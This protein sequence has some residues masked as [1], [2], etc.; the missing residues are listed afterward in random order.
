MK[1][2]T[3]ICASLVALAVPLMAQVAEKAAA[4]A[5]LDLNKV[6]LKGVTDKPQPLYKVGEEITF[7][8]WMDFAGQTPDKG[9]YFDWTLTGDDGQKKN[10]RHQVADGKLVVK[11]KLDKP[12]FVR[13]LAIGKDADGKPLTKTTGGG[14]SKRV[15]FDGGAG[16]E[17]EKL[18]GAPEPEDFD[19]FWKQQR[20]R[21][22]A[23]PFEGKAMMTECPSKDAAVKI[24]AVS[25]PCAGPRPVT[26]YMTI[27]AGAKPKSL[28]AH[29]VY[30]GYGL[31][32]QTPPT[33]GSKDKIQFFVNAHGYELGKDK[34]YQD[35]FFGSIREDGCSYG[36]SP[37]R[38]Q[39][40]ET[41]YFF[42]M[43]LRIMRSLQFVMSLPEWDGKNLIASG[44]SQGGLQT[45]WAAGLEPK[46]TEAYPSIP[47]C[48]DMQGKESFGRIHG[49]W[50][51][52]GTPALAYYDPI[53]IAKRIPRTC[54]VNITRAGLGD[55]CCPP[56][57]VAILYNNIKAPKE[58]HWV[59][60]STHGFVP[61]YPECQKFT[62]SQP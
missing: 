36:F 50:R 55:Y 58:I 57:G 7:T 16:A 42:G 54:K 53:N 40:R 59:Q 44:G 45:V 41:T 3:W 33:S 37:K 6:F 15:F 28:P 32:Y 35:A 46:V 23:V 13:L 11:T 51:I 22:A 62:Q 52:V 47:W 30:Y 19:E 1:L 39:N 18:Q 34:A 60:G 49:G 9:Y 27:P 14:D 20:E 25:V 21:L 56:S 4:P 12:G 8:L 48:C 17:I 43:T 26:G 24:Y 38:N 2:K 5:A 29:C 31:H 10:G 61:P